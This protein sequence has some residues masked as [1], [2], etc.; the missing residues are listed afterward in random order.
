LEASI[1]PEKPVLRTALLYG[2]GAGIVCILWVVGLYL[3]GNNP[4]GPKRLM[5]VFV[6]PIA[7]VLGQWRL[8]RYF[9][10]DGPGLLRSIGT[11]LLITLFAS[12]VSA[13][14]VYTFAR[15]TGPE[16]IAR[17]LAEMRHLLDQAKPMFLKEKNGRK[18]YEQAYRNL[19]Y[20][21]QDLATD[22]YVRKFLLGLLISIP[23]GIFLRK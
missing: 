22:D 12:V 3:A 17:H 10:P 13:T 19:A 1:S 4:Y 14:G 21:A 6:P 20:T 2:A 9:K 15:S 5:A 8:R 23:G 18:Q 11:G 7:V 16:P